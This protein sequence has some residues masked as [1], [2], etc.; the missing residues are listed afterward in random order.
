MPFSNY[1]FGGKTYEEIYNTSSSTNNANSGA[2]VPTTPVTTSKLEVP[3][4]G[5]LNTTTTS[6][7][8]QTT[9]NPK[10][11]YKPGQ[12]EA[13]DKIVQNSVNP[14]VKEVKRTPLSLPDFSELDAEKDYNETLRELANESA[15]TNRTRAAI[16]RSIKKS[17]RQI[18]RLTRAGSTVGS[19]GGK[20]LGFINPD[21]IMGITDFAVSQSAINRQA[22]KQKEALRKA[23]AGSQQDMPHERYTQFSDNGLMRMYDDRI[24]KIR[25]EEVQS[26][27]P[28]LRTAERLM[29]DQ[30]ADQLETQRNA[31]YSKMLGEYKNLNMNEHRNYDNMRTQIANE[32]RRN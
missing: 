17:D 27:D 9:S 26:N 11:G 7:N 12:Q 6:T 32:N 15:L 5:G 14:E 22:R 30:S 29:R 28:R 13:V 24:N 4:I 31:E 8:T 1:P 18:D 2:S 3:K 23:R 25:N 21:A 10:N 19:E 20:G 16:N